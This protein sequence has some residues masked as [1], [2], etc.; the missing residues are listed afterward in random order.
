M[1]TSQYTQFGTGGNSDFHIDVGHSVE[2]LRKFFDLT[3]L[4]GSMKISW[5]DR[6]MLLE[7]KSDAVIRKT[8]ADVFK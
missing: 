3:L 7:I 5:Q 4:P 8:K 6:S 2:V 1:S